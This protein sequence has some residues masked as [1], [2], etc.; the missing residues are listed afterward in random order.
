MIIFLNVFKAGLSLPVGVLG[1]RYIVLTFLCRCGK[2]ELQ[3]LK[4]DNNREYA[5]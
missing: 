1:S 2:D 4:V 3:Q 5:V